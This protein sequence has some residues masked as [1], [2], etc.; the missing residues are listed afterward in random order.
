MGDLDIAAKAL[1]RIEPGALLALA[2]RGARIRAIQA[3]ETELPAQALL[4]DKLFRIELEGVAEPRWQHFEVEAVW[5]SS[6][7]RE[8]FLYWCRG[9][10]RFMP[11]RS[12][13]L[14]KR[15]DRQGAPRGE[16][17]VDD[18]QDRLLT[19]R[20]DVLCAWELDAEE[21]LRGGDPGLLPLVPFAGG[22]RRT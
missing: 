7:P 16:Y 13:V 22:G 14:L 19:F 11:L 18:G 21:L 17:V 5:S 4:M 12:F 6:V 9:S 20:F 2:L 1:L 10:Q 15:G 8:A 3:E